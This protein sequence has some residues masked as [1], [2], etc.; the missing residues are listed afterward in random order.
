M[1]LA[2]SHQASRRCAYALHPPLPDRILRAHPRCRAR[3]L[4]SGRP[5]PR[6]R[7]LDR[8]R[9]DHRPRA[10]YH[11]RCHI[12]ET[13]HHQRVDPSARSH[14]PRANAGSPAVARSNHEPKAGMR[15]GYIGSAMRAFPAFALA[16]VVLSS[17]ACKEEGTIKVHSL[18]FNGVKAVDEGRLKDA[19]ATKQSSKLPWGKK[20]YFDRARFDADR[21]R[22]QAFYADRGYP[23]ARVT[24]FDVKLNDKQDEVDIAL[25]ISEGEPVVIEAVNF[26]GFD[27]MPQD[28]VNRLKKQH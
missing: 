6:Q 4:E 15:C 11:A 12:R 2:L 20:A 18:K 23:D 21:M 17:A 25:T 19:L 13:D 24:G 1:P 7:H 9:H 27:A 14:Q 22:I 16:F 28:H 10:R 8:H 26:V 3:P 5:R